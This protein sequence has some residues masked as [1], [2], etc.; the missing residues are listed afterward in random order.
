MPYRTLA[1]PETQREGSIDPLGLATPADCL[2]PAIRSRVAAPLRRL[3]GRRHRPANRALTSARR[4]A[5]LEALVKALADL[6]PPVGLGEEYRLTTTEMAGEGRVAHL[7][8][9]PSPDT[10]EG[11][12]QSIRTHWRSLES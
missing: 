6:A 1:D 4:G 11:R 8:A 2:P 9:F 5:V 3:R 12:G 7:M 10:P